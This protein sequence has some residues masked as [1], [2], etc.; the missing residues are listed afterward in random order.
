MVHSFNWATD[1]ALSLFVKPPMPMTVS[2]VPRMK[3]PHGHGAA[4][5]GELDACV[6]CV[7]DGVLEDLALVGGEFPATESAAPARGTSRATTGQAVR[8]PVGMPEGIP[9]GIAEGIP[10]D[11]G[12]SDWP[13]DPSAP[14]RPGMLDGIPDGMP[15]GRSEPF[16]PCPGMPPPPPKP[17]VCGPA[18]GLEPPMLLEPG[19]LNAQA[20]G[21]TRTDATAAPTATVSS[22]T[23]PS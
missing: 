22:S 7:L 18:V 1:G 21:A 12:S 4:L 16:P 5:D 11:E 14:G 13:E 20:P 8:S 9:E 17:S 6:G 10:P 2:S 3:A 15:D 19:T 23:V